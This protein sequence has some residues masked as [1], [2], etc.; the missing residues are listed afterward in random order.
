MKSYY[1]ERRCGTAERRD[2]AAGT[3]HRVGVCVTNGTRITDAAVVVHRDTNETRSFPALIGTA[4]RSRAITVTQAMSSITN[5]T[6]IDV[7]SRLR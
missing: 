5:S 2:V 7:A 6:I 4:S 3:S 1:R